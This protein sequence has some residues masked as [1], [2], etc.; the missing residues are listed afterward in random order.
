MDLWSLVCSEC[1]FLILPSQSACKV[2]AIVVLGL[3]MYV[4]VC[5]SHK[6]C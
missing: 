2:V 3:Y 6:K 4:E 5:I 1:D